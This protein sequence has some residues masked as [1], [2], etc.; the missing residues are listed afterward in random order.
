MVT[1]KRAE[2]VI[3]FLSNNGIEETAKK[4]GISKDT[5]DRYNRVVAQKL[6]RAPKVLLFDI[7]TAPMTVFTWSLFKPMISPSNIV[8]D[9]FIISWSAKWLFNPNTFGDVLTSKEA[10]AKDDKRVVTSLWKLF[11]EADIVIAHNGNR[12][13]IKKMNARFIMQ[14]LLPPTPYESIDTLLVAKKHFAFSSNKLDYLGH[15]MARRGKI[16]TN[17]QLWIDCIAGKKEAL[18]EMFTYNKE[19]VNILEEVYLQLRPWIK[20]HP[21]MG[22]YTD[23]HES[24]CPNCGSTHLDEIGDYTT[25]AGRF[26]SFRCMNPTCGAIGRMPANNLKLT[27]R[28]KLL[29][30]VA[31]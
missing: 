8:S 18:E 16:E 29:R 1:S 26:T 19:D 12:F 28:R 23:A 22:I 27:Q 3:V 30:S 17:F 6:P 7:E 2:E 15:L 31:R 4:F 5:I 13:D 14:H 24:V 25:M 10:L 9:W 20:S 21:N 11:N